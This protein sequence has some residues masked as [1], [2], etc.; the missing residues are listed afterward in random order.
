MAIN[1]PRHAPPAVA[2]AA[3]AQARRRNREVSS[4]RL[5]TSLSS[6]PAAPVQRK[7]AACAREDKEKAAIQPRLEVGEANDKY[8]SEADHIAGKVMAMRTTDLTT[9]SGADNSVQRAC[10]SCS[11]A[12]DDEVQARR[13]TTTS[14][15]GKAPAEP[16]L[17][18]KASD[19]LEEDSPKARMRSDNQGSEQI[20]ATDSQLT[21]GGTPLAPATQSFFESRMGRDLS[22]V[23]VHKNQTS[24]HLSKSIRARAFTYRN[25]IWLGQQ[26]GETPGFTMAHELAHVM[27]QTSPGPVGSAGGGPV[28]AYRENQVNS[29]RDTKVRRKTYP[30]FLPG[31]TTASGKLHS[32]MH[33]V[34]QKAVRTVNGDVIT[35]VPIPGANRNF[36]DTKKC[37]F[38]DFYTAN[39]VGTGRHNIPVPGVEAL[40]VKAPP[41][42][43]GSTT[44]PTTYQLNNFSMSS[45]KASCT[46]VPAF[47]LRMERGSSGYS[48]RKARAPVLYGSKLVKMDKAPAN[49]K[50]GELKP[51]HDP[52]Y[53][54]KGVTQLNNYIKG[55][56]VLIG[57]TNSHLSA[58]GR[59]ERWNGNP[60]KMKSLTIPSGWDARGAIASG[61]S[62]P[63]NDL[64][65]RGTVKV[66]SVPA[67]GG[68][69]KKSKVRSVTSGSPTSI[70][71]RWMLSQDSKRGN[72]GIYVY[73]LAPKPADINSVLRQHSTDQ[74]FKKLAREVRKIQK[75]L[76]RPPTAKKVRRLPIVEAT[77]AAPHKLQR[78]AKDTFERSKWEAIRRGHKSHPKKSKN[79]LFEEFNSLA[80]DAMREK[81]TE[82]GSIAQWV[83][84]QPVPTSTLSYDKRLASKTSSAAKDFNS[85]R[86]VAFWSG[87]KATPLGIFREK[88]GG[89][90]VAAIKKFDS[91]RKKV[92]ARF[93]KKKGKHYLGGRKG[94]ILKAAAKVA[95]IVI[96]KVVAPFMATMFNT[97]IECGME[98]FR[99]KMK[100]LLVDTP[101]DALI[102][103]ADQLKGKIDKITSDSKA[104]FD[105]LIS[106]SIGKIQRKVNK[107]V[108]DVKV[109]TKIAGGIAEIAK[110]LRI[111]SC[112][113]GLA[114]AP[115][116]VGIGAVIGCGAAVVDWILSQFGL[117]PL[118]YIIAL[119]LQS[120]SSQNLI[121]RLISKMDFMKSLPKLAG[122]KIVKLAQAA[123]RNNLK[124]EIAGKT[125][126]Q[127]A[128]EMF[129]DIDKKSFPD[130]PYKEFKCGSV[131]G[132]DSDATGDDY[133]RGKSKVT[134]VPDNIKLRKKGGHG[135]S[136]K[137]KSTGHEQPQQPGGGSDSGSGK[138]EKPDSI[139]QGK[140]ENGTPSSITLTIS[141][142]FELNKKYSGSTVCTATLS[143]IDSKNNIYG[144]LTV[145]VK[146]IQ[147]SVI[148]GT[149]AIQ[150]YFT[151]LTEGNKKNLI[152]H[153][154]KTGEKF[155]IHNS[156]SQLV[157]SIVKISSGEKCQ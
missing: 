94:T 37:G 109:L 42:P 15:A 155:E 16:R 143:A 88:F 43:A 76:M 140:I 95:A 117:S 113:A 99:A 137:K 90:F 118:E 4:P 48:L 58:A 124:T 28:M 29:N 87:L 81:V 65:V 63:V 31:S 108:G 11:A 145:K 51:A 157:T 78:R 30:Y 45:S 23:R 149:N 60:G 56:N 66:P 64:K 26:E 120:C 100:S 47:N 7:C 20:A 74:D 152:L 92:K 148:E 141:G 12:Q 104:Y 35:E 102:D 33:D 49:I 18:R 126:G 110:G 72:D 136:E 39:A 139:S 34:A 147:T 107:F 151:P 10:S 132:G 106:D 93:A 55:L 44:Q 154:S 138:K 68:G 22:T 134:D 86:S 2:K 144:P 128:S 91:F 46:K 59:T 13:S 142:P 75:P 156:F 96:P 79:N 71:G 77:P 32:R 146:P 119:T 103:T 114:S 112:I 62:W 54:G 5:L 57:A 83:R 14:S 67:T 111:A 131:D 17:Q 61:S 73:F 36:V 135:A 98:G 53:R 125:L 115:E 50:L 41:P 69:K 82:A 121:G 52:G 25:H 116:T 9:A 105:K 21:S 133:T 127:H 97:I 89:L 38:A 24:S 3:P 85:L 122:V 84:E 130:T 153:D 101:I 19:K 150:F 27:Q 40:P 80:P 6:I 8:E 129:C 70:S 1:S 123:L